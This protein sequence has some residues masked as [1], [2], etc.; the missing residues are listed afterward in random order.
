MYR[1]AIVSA[2]PA[3]AAFY[4]QS[5]LEPDM[6]NVGWV[7]VS[8]NVATNSGNNSNNIIW[9]VYKS[10]GTNNQIGKD[11]YAGFGWDNASNANLFATIFEGWTGGSTN[12]CTGYMPN[13]NPSAVNYTTQ[14]NAWC[15][16]NASTLPNTPGYGVTQNAAC[17]TT[18]SRHRR[19]QRLLDVL[20][21]ISAVHNH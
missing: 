18:I 3:P 17:M 1:S 16:V 15:N 2:N 14:A 12:T 5:C 4:V 7:K 13:F 19:H 9:N 20:L 6:I 10:P 8:T 11:W 21:H